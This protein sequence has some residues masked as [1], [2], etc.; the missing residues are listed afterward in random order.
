MSCLPFLTAIDPKCGSCTALCCR[1]FA[2]EIDKPT[3]ERDFD[4]L[5]WYLLHEKVSIFV[6]DGT[7][8]LNIEQQCKALGPDNLCTIYE[9]RPS[10]CREYKNDHCDKDGGDFDMLFETPEQL[11]AYQAKWRAERLRKRRSRAKAKRVRAKVAGRVRAH[12]AA[13]PRR[14]RRSA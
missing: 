11:L 7:W 3:S 13:K 8:F 9:Q 2:L 1:Y 12:R 6:D 4:D 14:R 5:R 10:I